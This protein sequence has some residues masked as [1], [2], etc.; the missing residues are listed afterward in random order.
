MQEIIK[1]YKASLDK[2]L[3]EINQILKEKKVDNSE[4]GAYCEE[5]LSLS[6]ESIINKWSEGRKYL[7]TLFVKEAFAELYPQKIIKTSICID[8]I[9]N[10][11]DDLLDEKMGDDE[12]KL[13]IIEF[14]RVF[15]IYNYEHPQKNIQICMGDYFN[16][17]IS[18]ATMENYY[19]DIIGNEKKMEKIVSY[20]IKVLD[21]RSMDIDIF[22]ELVILNNGCYNN[23]EKNEIEKM[24][25]IFRALNIVKK[26]ILDIEHDKKT[27]QESIV[28]KILEKKDCNFDKYA[29]SL[30][31][32]YL[33]EAK[34]IKS[35]KTINKNYTIP[36]NNFY[37]MIEK[38]GDKI[39]R[40]AKDL[41]C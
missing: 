6:C 7:R 33:N 37:K 16:K 2:N 13:Y 36:I 1:I 12:K 10:I 21:C 32:Y 20:S 11:L 35:K 14:L 29:L 18:L 31:N 17:L 41:S 39:I 27:N 28:S 19:K 34:K 5:L 3:I 38:S 9:I 4:V 40:L 22:N 23:E 8:A 25:R 30:Y 24:G 26:D 15:S